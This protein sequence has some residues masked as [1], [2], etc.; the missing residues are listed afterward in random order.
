MMSTP[1]PPS[2]TLSARNGIASEVPGTSWWAIAVLAIGILV[3]LT[4]VLGTVL[5]LGVNDFLSIVWVY[6]TLPT[7]IINLIAGITW[8]RR[9][10]RV[11]TR[12][13]GR[14]ATSNLV[15]G[16][17]DVLLGMIPFAVILFFPHLIF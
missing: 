3:F 17:L 9:S 6:V 14:I 4:V 1:K 7:G 10:G 2:S 8:R 5:L 13:G 16:V 11:R 15:I 12:S